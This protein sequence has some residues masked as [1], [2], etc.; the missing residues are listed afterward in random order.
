MARPH[1][2]GIDYFSLDVVLDDKFELFEAEFGLQGFGF[3]IKIFQKIY[4]ANG[5]YY[6]WSEDEKLLFSK[7]VNV[8]IDLINDYINSALKRD[9]LSQSI[10]EKYNILTSKGIQKRF[11]EASKRR[12]R[13][14]IIKEY[15]L[16]DIASNPEYSCLNNKV[17]YVSNNGDNDDSNL[18]NDNNNSQRKG[19]ETKE[20][21]KEIIKKQFED[22][23]SIY[24]KKVKKQKA[25]EW[26]E[27]NKPTE[28]LF[29]IMLTALKEFVNSKEWKENNGQ[30]IPHPTTW[31]NQK[32]WEDLINGEG[33]FTSGINGEH[34]NQYDEARGT[35]L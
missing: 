17:V 9:I 26:F 13:I 31:L 34:N 11:L 5:Y 7:R 10:Y 3:I 21:E 16:I 24:P 8:D 2:Q 28:E 27:K 14:E 18:K 33:G 19:K 23:W 20:K 22:F 15:F 6:K 25:K 12:N 35:T 32:R 29:V 4:E 30:F 1:K